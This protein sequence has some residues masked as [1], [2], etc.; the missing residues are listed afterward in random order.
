MDTNLKT[1]MELFAEN[2]QVMR[3]GFRWENSLIYPL[4]SIIYTSKNLKINIDKIKEADAIIK[5]NMGIFSSFRGVGRLALATLLSLENDP[6]DF[7]MKVRDV[8]EILR[9][10]FKTSSFL[11][12]TAFMIAKN[13]KT[14]EHLNVTLKARDMYKLMKANHPLLTSGEDTSFAALF[15]M[16]PKSNEEI[17]DDVEECY[18]LLKKEFYSS[19]A[20]QSLSHV[21]AFSPDSPEI[22]CNKGRSEGR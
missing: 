3:K 17:S 16:S 12:F 7:F 14:D 9:E 20:V 6:E 21:L 19:D 8:Y 11:P 22:K 2:T 4:C 15:A 18:R 13:V 5:N 10:E 1:S